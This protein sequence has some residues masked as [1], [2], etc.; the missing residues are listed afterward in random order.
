[1]ALIV[2]LYV[3]AVYFF[4][5]EVLQIMKQ[6]FAYF[7]VVWNIQDIS[8]PALILVVISYHAK[9]LSDDTNTF[10]IP[11]LVLSC[12]AAASLLLWSKFLYFLRIFEST[13]NY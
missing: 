7:Y 1:M 12:H 8:I 9:Q 2:I 11:D 10:V 6:G 5:A 4:T 13:G 3:L